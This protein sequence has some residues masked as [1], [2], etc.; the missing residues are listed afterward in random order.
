MGTPAQADWQEGINVNSNNLP[1]SNSQ[2]RKTETSAI[3]E[4]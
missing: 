4:S 1:L 3:E 2:T